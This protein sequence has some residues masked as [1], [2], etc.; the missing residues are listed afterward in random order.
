MSLLFRLLGLPLF[1]KRCL[2]CFLAVHV[3]YGM[4]QEPCD[5]QGRLYP[6][7]RYGGQP[8]ASII[9]PTVQ[10]S[11]C[12]TRIRS[13]T[14]LY[15]CANLLSKQLWNQANVDVVNALNCVMQV[16]GQWPVKYKNLEYRR[17]LR[18]EIESFKKDFEDEG[19]KDPLLKQSF[20]E[21][22]NCFE[23]F[24][25]ELLRAAQASP[26]EM[27]LAFYC[28]DSRGKTGLWVQQSTADQG[29]SPLT[30]QPILD[31]EFLKEMR[32]PARSLPTGSRAAT[33]SSQE[34]CEMHVTEEYLGHLPLHQVQKPNIKGFSATVYSLSE[35]A[36]PV[37]K[38]DM[39][40][41]KSPTIVRAN[42]KTERYR[43]TAARDNQKSPVDRYPGYFNGD[44]E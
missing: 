21:M 44:V 7:L 35:P 13:L 26:L 37:V 10:P 41:Q 14:P 9:C 2:F 11:V 39:S 27:K 18:R 5:G 34:E 33:P 24:F 20:S 40:Q 25:Y 36:T 43:D 42:L 12:V 29:W 38:K 19:Q 32:H 15:A 23:K 28:E 4:Q 1:L 3:C 6:Q 22:K 8:L 31:Q 16:V 30:A 17:N